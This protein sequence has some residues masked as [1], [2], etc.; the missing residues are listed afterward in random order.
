[1]NRAEQ[2]Q[3]GVRL[4]VSILLGVILMIAL[5]FVG[6]QWLA[7]GSGNPKAPDLSAEHAVVFPLRQQISS[8]SLRTE[9]GTTY[10]K[11]D[12]A[13][14]WT[15]AFLAGTRCTDNCA[16]TLQ[17]LRGLRES[18]EPSHPRP[19]FLMVATDPHRD[20]P[21]ALRDYLE[22]YGDG[23]HAVTGNHDSLAAFARDLKSAYDLPAGTTSR[24]QIERLALIDPDAKLVALL[25]PPFQIQ[26]LRTAYLRTVSWEKSMSRLRPGP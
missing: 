1:M 21:Q 22:P 16:A 25:E 10:S 9:D 5:L 23:F 2:A 24:S 14:H 8:F 20:T 11:K 3:R 17:T 7:S 19:R 6:E 13:G 26:T 18:I 12:L 4:T 15:L